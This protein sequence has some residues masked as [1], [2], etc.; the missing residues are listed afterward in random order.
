[1]R[2]RTIAFAGSCQ[3]K[4][5]GTVYGRHIAPLRDEVVSIVWLHPNISAAER[6]AALR[7][8]AEADVVVEQRF[9]FAN[10]VPEDF[11]RAAVRQVPFPYAAA[12]FYWP[13]AT[14]GHACREPQPLLGN[15]MVYPNELGD[16][17][18]NQ[19]IRDG[20]APDAAVQRYL[21]MTWSGSAGSSGWRRSTWTSSAGATRRPAS[22]ALIT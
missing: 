2:R 17:V 9:D 16:R 11:F 21:E 3:A 22:T 4:S 14:D 7:T 15:D 20:V 19:M 12:P 18:L 10:P 6:E 1:V 5:L 13:F 8:L